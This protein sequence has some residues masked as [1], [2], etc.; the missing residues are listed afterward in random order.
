M[1]VLAKHEKIVLKG[2]AHI[3]VTPATVR[4]I[5]REFTLKMVFLFLISILQTFQPGDVVLRDH[6]SYLEENPYGL[7]T[8][9][10]GWWEFEFLQRPLLP[11]RKKRSNFRDYRYLLG[12]ERV[13]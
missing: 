4:I 3:L 11:P 1:T 8:D 6:F 2:E 7:R 9:R 5:I 12:N 13:T 10:N